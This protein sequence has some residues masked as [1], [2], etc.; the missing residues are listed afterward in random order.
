M[1]T[2]PVCRQ[3]YNDSEQ[4]FCLNDGAIL[5]DP[6]DDAPP[7]LM[8]DPPR[9]TNETWR[10]TEQ[11]GWQSQPLAAP[12]QNQSNIQNQ[13]FAPPMMTM[14]K[15]DQTLPTVS[16]VLGILGFVLVCCWGGIPLGIAAAITGYLGMNNANNDPQQY[17]GRGMAIAGLILGVVS[18]LSSIVYIIIAIFGSFK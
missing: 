4:K 11:P 7:T 10:N 15:P 1:K 13:G 16:L 12:W 18:I 9:V 3:N 14:P 6:H 2:C 17:G 8:M 5:T